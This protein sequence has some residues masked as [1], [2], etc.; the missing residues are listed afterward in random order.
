MSRAAISLNQHAGKGLTREHIALPPSLSHTLY[1]HNPIFH[2]GSSLFLSV[3]VARRYTCPT[4]LNII[5]PFSKQRAPL[6]DKDKR[7]EVKQRQCI[8]HNISRGWT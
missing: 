2:V 4:E 6:R 5:R 3:S 1:T 8:K 7:G